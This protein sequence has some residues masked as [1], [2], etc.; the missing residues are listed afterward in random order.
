VE[1]LARAFQRMLETPAAVEAI[2]RLGEEVDYLGPDQFER[3]WRA[4]YETFRTLGQL[5]KR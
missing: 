2:Q 3:Y 4:E 1:K 5:F